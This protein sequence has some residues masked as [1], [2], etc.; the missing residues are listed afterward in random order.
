[1]DAAAGE[2]TMMLADANDIGGPVDPAW[3][4]AWRQADARADRAIRA[5][6]A[7]M[8][9]RIDDVGLAG[10]LTELAG[11]LGDPTADLIVTALVLAANGQAQDLG[12][13]L[14][15]LA[16]TA[17]DEATMRLRVDAARA[18]TR[19][20]VRVILAVTGAMAAALVVFNRAYL[21][22]YRTAGGQAVLVVVFAAFGTAGWWLTAMARYQS[23][24]R[25]LTGQ[26]S[27]DWR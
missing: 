14:G 12:E 8:V 17:R 16:V 10:A 19:T 6:V 25:F 20:A 22:P 9:A 5:E 23:P 2:L 3:L 13:L 21:A 7:A 1:V 4:D 24:E 26:P 11:A 18:R 27:G 15:A